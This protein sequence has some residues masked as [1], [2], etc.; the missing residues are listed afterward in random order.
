M[1]YKTIYD[2]LIK[3]RSNQALLKEEYYE[4]HHIIPRCMGGTD[5]P[6]NLIKLTAR[7][8]FLAHYLLTKIYPQQNK[9]FYALLCMI[10]DPHNNRRYTSKAHEIA[11]KQFSKMQSVRQTEN[12][13]MWTESAK[14]KISEKMKGDNNPMRKY[15]EKNP[16]WGNSYVRGKKWYN[17]GLQN[18]YLSSEEII[19]D[20][21]TIGMKYSPK[22]RK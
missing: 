6:R 5:D 20:G 1:N 7:E 17:N 18:L 11:K 13:M 19:P 16:A 14:K 3:S 9:L 22:K 12:N 4:S 15:P 10:R 21:Y 8:H 2:D